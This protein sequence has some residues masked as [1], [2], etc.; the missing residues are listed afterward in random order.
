MVLFCFVFHFGF[1]IKK[2]TRLLSIL[3]ESSI[4][5][6]EEQEKTK[7]PNELSVYGGNMTDQPAHKLVNLS[8]S[9]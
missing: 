9:E 1:L 2:S 3:Q 5:K 4:F 6:R 8:T 7:K